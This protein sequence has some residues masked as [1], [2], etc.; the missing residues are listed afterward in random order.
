VLFLGSQHTAGPPQV[1]N[2]KSEE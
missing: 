1:L 2:S